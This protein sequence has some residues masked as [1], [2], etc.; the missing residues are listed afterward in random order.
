MATVKCFWLKPR[1]RARRW[2]RRFT[3]STDAQCPNHGT[4]GHDAMVQ[5]EDA[6]IKMLADGCY[7][8]DSADVPRDDPRWPQACACGYQFRDSD[9]W[10]VH[11]QRIY[12]RQ[13]TGEET[14]LRDAPPGAMWDAPWLPES[15]RGPDGRALVLMLPCNLEW[16]I[17][18]PATNGPGWTRTGEPPNIT[19]NPS[20]GK[21]DKDGK[22]LYHGWLRNGG[23]IDA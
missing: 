18:G 14:T 6:K 22:W 13:D 3:Y 7:E 21:L 9:L 5:I 11:N 2:L 20:I 15:H 12:V 23:L 1:D 17:D 19:A 10:Q 16:T 8:C 4:W